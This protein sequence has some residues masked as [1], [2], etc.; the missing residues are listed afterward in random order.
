M[1]RLVLEAVGKSYGR[2]RVLSGVDAQWD[3]GR[4]VALVG[5][6][7]GGKSTLLKILAG[8]IVAD[9]GRVT[10]LE[11]FTTAYLP[12]RLAFARGWTARAWLT[13]VA[14]WKGAGRGKGLRSRVDQVLAEAGLADA[15]TKP[16]ATFSQGMLRRL[17][18]AQTRLTDADLVLLDEPEGGLDPHWMV[19]LE[20]ELTRLRTEGRTLVFATHLLELTDWADEVLVFG[21]GRVIERTPADT[22]NLP[23]P[24]RRRRLA[25]LLGDQ[26]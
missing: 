18:S 22:W 7:G 23:G 15:A 13:L 16:V 3:Q 25:A 11:A 21:A 8:V 5:A 24:E 9:E 6:N 14:S 4:A 2:H 12:D 10:G 17:L 19:H 1:K 20:A 26:P